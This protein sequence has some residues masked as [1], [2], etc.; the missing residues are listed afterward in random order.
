MTEKHDCMQPF[1]KQSTHVGN[2]TNIYTVYLYSGNQNNFEKHDII[3]WKI[4]LLMDGENLE[5]EK[6][7]PAGIFK[8]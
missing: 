8:L 2:Y 6:S 5:T 4:W 7:Q 1:I 3:Y